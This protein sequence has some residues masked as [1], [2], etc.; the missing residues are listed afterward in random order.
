[1]GLIKRM[2]GLEKRAQGDTAGSRFLPAFFSIFGGGQSDSGIPVDELTALTA[3]AVWA[4]VSVI[5]DGI[6]ALPVHVLASADA[7]KQIDHPVYHL[8]HDSPNEYMTSSTFRQTFLLNLL[9]WGNGY[10]FIDKDELGRPIALYPLRS[11]DVW[12]MRQNGQLVYIARVGTMMT[13]VYP[14][15]ML[16]VLGMSIDGIVGLSPIAYARQTVGLSIAMERYAAKFFSN[17]GNLSGI[18]KLPPNMN[19]DAKKAFVQAWREQHT[20]VENL[21][22]IGVLP[23]GFGFTPTGTDPEQAQMLDTRVHQVR[24][25]ARIFRVPLHKIGD[26]E[27]ATFSNIEHQSLEFVQDCLMPWV[28]RFEQE[29]NRK[30]FLSREAAMF[31]VKFNFDALLRGDTKSRYESYNLA[32]QGCWQTV[33]EIRAKE[34]LPPTAGGDVLRTPLNMGNAASTPPDDEADDSSTEPATRS[35]ARALIEDAARRVLIKE[36]KAIQ[37]AAKKYQTRPE[38]FRSWADNFY[39]SHQSLVARVFATPM[40]AAA[41]DIDAGTYAHR[42]CEESRSAIMNAVTAGAAIDDVLDEFES[43]RPG[44]IALQIVQPEVSRAAA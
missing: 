42:H 39:R 21:L 16:H 43:I 17:G 14:D 1:M 8:L 30:L 26:L 5:S 10:A 18:L 13:T 3:S 40:K 7:T 35:A 28:V 20:G 31:D 37:R 33:N 24:E 29:C 25:T 34:G 32:L 11:C 4:C 6:A 41:I 38:E 27:R 44:D 12:P 2:F 36:S 23:D 22:K 19:D 15:Q 9:L